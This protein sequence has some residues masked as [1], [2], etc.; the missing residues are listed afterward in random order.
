MRKH[1]WFL[2]VIYPIKTDGTYIVEQ[3][4]HCTDNVTLRRVQETIVTVEKQWLLHI[5]VCVGG[6]GGV[7]VDARARACA[8]ARVALLI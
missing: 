8:Y 6:G 4:K 1:L 2:T 5:S 7:G 3:D